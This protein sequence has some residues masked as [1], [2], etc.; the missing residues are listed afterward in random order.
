MAA[1]KYAPPTNPHILLTVREAAV[2]SR[3]S[4][5]FIRSRIYDGTIPAVRLSARAVRIRQEDLDN[6]L[7]HGRG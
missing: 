2:Y 6:F 3:M 7:V 5:K 1:R 4:E